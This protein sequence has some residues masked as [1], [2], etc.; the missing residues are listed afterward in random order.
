LAK[1]EKSSGNVY[2]D[3]GLP[4]AEEMLVKAQLALNI[5]RIVKRRR[6]TQKEAA[7]IMGLSQA[8]VS[9]MLRGR[10]R[11]IGEAKML[12][13]I[14]ALGNDIEIRVKPIRRHKTPGSISVVFAG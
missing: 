5:A 6:L 10:F 3:L 9:D 12:D 2:A 8:K 7:G 4:D 14:A 13:C 11:G 1:I